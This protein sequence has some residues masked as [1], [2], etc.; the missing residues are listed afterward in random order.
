MQ[1]DSAGPA[2]YGGRHV[3]CPMLSTG[4]TFREMLET[5]SYKKELIM[6]GE[7]A[8]DREGVRGGGPGSRV[9]GALDC[10]T[11]TPGLAVWPHFS[12]LGA[13]L[14]SP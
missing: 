4:Y 2:Q 5:V 7:S 14:D 12:M 11:G 6:T 8:Y 10:A 3:C 13:L 9:R 1:P